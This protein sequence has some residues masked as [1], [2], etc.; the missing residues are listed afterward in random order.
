MMMQQEVQEQNEETVCT[1]IHNIVTGTYDEYGEIYLGGSGLKTYIKY[2]SKFTPFQQWTLVISILLVLGLT[3]YSIYLH[4]LVTTN[5]FVWRTRRGYSND[6]K[7][8]PSKFGR[9]HSGIM[10]GRSFDKGYLA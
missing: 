7:S 6:P 10:S 5:R 4:R 2:V 3:S 8:D 1:F 9:D